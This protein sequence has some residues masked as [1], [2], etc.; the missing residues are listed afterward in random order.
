M[1]IRAHPIERFGSRRAVY[2]MALQLLQES[3]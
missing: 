1:E 2:L 3:V